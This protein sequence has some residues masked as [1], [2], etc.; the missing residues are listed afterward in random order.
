MPEGECDF[1]V[2]FH[3]MDKSIQNSIL[4]QSDKNIQNTLILQ[5]KDVQNSFSISEKGI[6]H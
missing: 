2:M 6:Q 5:D 3:N 1:T 4:S